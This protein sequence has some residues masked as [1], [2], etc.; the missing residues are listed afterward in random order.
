ML[1]YIVVSKEEPSS[2]CLDAVAIIKLSAYYCSCS[3]FWEFDVH[4]SFLGVCLVTSG[5][6]MLTGTN[7]S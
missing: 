4:S 6:F 5:N 2:N 3:E 1:L 7:L